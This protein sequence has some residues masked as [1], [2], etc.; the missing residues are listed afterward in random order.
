MHEFDNERVTLME[1][2]MHKFDTEFYEQMTQY[3]LAIFRKMAPSCAMPEEMHDAFTDALVD[4]CK[5]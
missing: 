5:E 3:Y 1:K 4:F 2:I